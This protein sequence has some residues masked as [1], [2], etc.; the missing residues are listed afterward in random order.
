[1][2]YMLELAARVALSGRD[3]RNFKLGCVAR[4][5]DGAI[6]YSVNELIRFPTPSAHAEARV[7]KK[8]GRGATLWVAR[9]TK[10]STWTIARPCARC[11][12]KIRN[13]NVQ[14]VYYTIAPNEFGVWYPNDG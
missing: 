1:M 3:N 8:S 13:M 5:K 2:K 14:K 9:I 10:D 11:Q 4:R 12:A 6:V 7:L